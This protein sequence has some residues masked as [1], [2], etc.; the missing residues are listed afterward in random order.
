[1]LDFLSF[2]KTKDSFSLRELSIILQKQSIDI[3]TM[4]KKFCQSK[5]FLL[6]ENIDL[7]NM[8]ILYEK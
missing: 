8:V 1:M 7:R 3:L 2:A 4:Y 5:D 6:M